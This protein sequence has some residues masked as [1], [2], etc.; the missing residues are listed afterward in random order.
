MS[1]LN[2]V[3]KFKCFV[4][5]EA[6]LLADTDQPTLEIDVHERRNSRALCS[7]C[8]QPASSYD[9]Q[10]MRRFEF[11]PLWGIKVF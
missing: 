9:R 11:I 6:R 1:I 8:E 3:Q 5:G 10:R 7:V 2:Q 4:Y